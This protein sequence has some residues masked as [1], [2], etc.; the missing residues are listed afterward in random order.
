MTRF[1]AFRARHAGSPADVSFGVIL[2]LVIAAI[3][4]VG[5]YDAPVELMG[6]K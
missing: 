2:A 3:L 1:L 5:A 6:I 4:F